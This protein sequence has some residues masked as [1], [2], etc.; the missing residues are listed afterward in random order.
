MT[1][2]KFQLADWL[3]GKANAKHSPQADGIARAL[4]ITCSL[5]RDQSGR[6]LKLQVHVEKIGDM[7][8]VECEGRFVQSDA[9]FKLRNAVTSV[10]DVRIIVVDLSQ[11]RVTEGGGLDMLTFLGRRA[12]DHIQFKLFNPTKSVRDRL[13]AANSMRA[14]DLL[15]FTK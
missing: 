1:S 12:Q 2:R 3:Y 14:F 4:S 10:R 5:N 8:V 13:E 7:A 11:V 9:A 15:R 6:E